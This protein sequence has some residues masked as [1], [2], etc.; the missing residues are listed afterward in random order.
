[1]SDEQE[2]KDGQVMPE[3]P[4][5]HSQDDAK[6]PDLKG[7]FW[8]AKILACAGLVFF[9]FEYLF[10][11]G[12]VASIEG[13]E[14]NRVINGIKNPYQVEK[15]KCNF[16]M[17]RMSFGNNIE[18]KIGFVMIFKISDEMADLTLK[19]NGENLNNFKPTYYGENWI[20][21]R[22]SNSITVSD[23]KYHWQPMYEINQL[24][25]D[26]GIDPIKLNEK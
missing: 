15:L 25:V 26:Y 9:G 12:D 1:M 22:N 11:Y 20:F 5:D 3:Q 17:T 16:N 2:H 18:R 13:E 7:A 24:F 8:L 23:K 21:M 19:S 10:Y 14:K 4:K 6:L